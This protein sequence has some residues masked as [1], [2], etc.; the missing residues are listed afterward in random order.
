MESLHETDENGYNMVHRAAH[1]GHADVV[2]LAVEDYKVDHAARDKVS[3][4]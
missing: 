2:R 3:V 1:G 4:H